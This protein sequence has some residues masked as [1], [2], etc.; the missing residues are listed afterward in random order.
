[1]GNNSVSVDL[2]ARD[3][4]ALCWKLAKPSEL[5]GKCSHV[6]LIPSDIYPFYPTKQARQ[7]KR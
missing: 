1:M 3:W 7:E 2:Q 6:F 5:R 4:N